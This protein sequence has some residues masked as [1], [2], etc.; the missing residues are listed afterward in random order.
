MESENM[1]VGIY[2]WED[3]ISK[4][5]AEL[6]NQNVDTLSKLMLE[7]KIKYQQDIS[8]TRSLNKI[9]LIRYMVAIIDCSSSMKNTDY[10]PTRK[11]ITE[12]YLGTFVQN[13]ADHNP[14]S[15]L[16]II[17][18]KDKKAV[19]AGNFESSF[20]D[21]V[22]SSLDQTSIRVRNWLVTVITK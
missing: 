2:R 17:F 5:F 13:Y 20:Q 14:L 3:D 4:P 12:K 15:K 22:Y 16:A 10:R 8:K 7:E 19:I 21:H 6:K 9:P 11:N 18:T 1:N